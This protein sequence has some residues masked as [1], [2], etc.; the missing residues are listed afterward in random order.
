MSSKIE[1]KYFFLN[2]NAVKKEDI[3]WSL[4][5]YFKFSDNKETVYLTSKK[6]N[7]IS[8]LRDLL[9]KPVKMEDK[10]KELEFEKNLKEQQVF[11]N[12]NITKE[13]LADLVNTP[14]KIGNYMYKRIKQEDSHTLYEN[15]YNSDKFKSELKKTDPS[16]SYTYKSVHENNLNTFGVGRDTYS[17]VSDEI[18]MGKE[19]NTNYNNLGIKET[20]NKTDY[21]EIDWDFITQLAERMNQNKNKYPKNNWKKSIDIDLLKQSLLRHVLAILNEEYKDSDREFGHLESIALNAQFIN[22]QLRVK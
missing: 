7:P 15:A 6:E 9:E 3:D 5:I 20:E 22:Y 18:L 12:F 13:D 2:G 4:P 10:D 8:E 11:E 21:S 16:V 19:I 17:T 14:L 1:L